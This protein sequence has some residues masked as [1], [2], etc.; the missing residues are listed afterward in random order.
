VLLF[1][2]PLFAKP[3]EDR[4][5]PPGMNFC[6]AADIFPAAAPRNDFFFSD[7]DVVDPSGAKDV[8]DLAGL[9]GR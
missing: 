6:C 1:A 2:A 8:W 5:M 7:F 9:S 4:D 3:V